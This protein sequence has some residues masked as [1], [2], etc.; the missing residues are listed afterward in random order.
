[1]VAEIAAANAGEARAR[2]TISARNTK[3]ATN[4]AFLDARDA[5]EA[6]RAPRQKSEAERRLDDVLQNLKS[7]KS[8]AAKEAARR[9]IEQLK[10][11]LQALKLAAGSAAA[12]GDAKL[13]RKVAKEI[14][15]AARALGKA[16]NE[17]GGG[18]AA[19]AAATG[20]GSAEQAA[21]KNAQPDGKVE[22]TAADRAGEQMK[23]LA[24][25]NDLANL[26]AEASALLKELK[27]IMR[28]LRE[29]SFHPGLDKKDRTEMEKMFAEAERELSGLQAAS[30]PAP[31]SAVDV[32]A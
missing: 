14:R 4:R 9:K 27:K 12:T 30:Q 19:P 17:A 26:K 2:E 29:T 3:G 23:A 28:K 16:L 5:L 11:K 31:G 20:V 15:D 21:Q 24:T 7:S 18:G 8:E 6:L 32:S 10:A 25:G 13:A 1:M 22:K